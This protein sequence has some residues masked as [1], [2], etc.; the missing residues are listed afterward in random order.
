M[1]KS[2]LAPFMA[3]CLLATPA[4]DTLRTASEAVS[5][6]T[7]PTPLGDRTVMDERAMYAAEALYNVP[8]QAYVTA[9]TRGLLTPAVRAAV[10]PILIQARQA[11]LAVREAYRVGDATTFGQRVAALR[12]LKDRAMSLL[13]ATN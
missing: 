3:L 7:S 13:P 9:D 2:L 11:L 10:R 12:S 4:C 1:K 8:A 6:A 5:L